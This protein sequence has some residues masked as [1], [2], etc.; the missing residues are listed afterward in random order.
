MA[1]LKCPDGPFVV[2]VQTSAAEVEGLVSSH[3]PRTSLPPESKQ[4]TGL[5]LRKATGPSAG[6]KVAVPFPSVYF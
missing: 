2:S 5:P 4:P 1:S 3:K 6:P